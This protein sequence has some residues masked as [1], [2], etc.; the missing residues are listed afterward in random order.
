MNTLIRGLLVIAFL[1][2]ASG[3]VRADEYTDTIAL[4]KNAGRSGAFFPKAYGYAVF[5]TIGKGGFI[6]GAAHGNGHVYAHG[7]YIGDTSMTQVSVGF[8]AG[9]Q[10]YSEIIFFEDRR[11]LDDFTSGNFEFSADA[12]AVAIT[13]G[14]SASAGTDGTTGS[15]SGGQK[16]AATSGSYYKGTVVF[17]IAKGGLMYQATIGGQK[18]SYKPVGASSP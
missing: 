10:A 13:A 14:A 15:A 16:D 3:P 1:V 7:K 12:S 9:G 5:P 8:Q 18:F 6:V 11:T 4:F 17:T 2:V